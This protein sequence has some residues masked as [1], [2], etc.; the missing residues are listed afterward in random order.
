MAFE[1]RHIVRA[2]PD[3]ESVKR[4]VSNGRLLKSLCHGQ[5]ASD[6]IRR[7]YLADADGLLI[8]EIRTK[9]RSTVVGLL[10]YEVSDEYEPG[11]LMYIHVVCS[12]M[13]GVG[14]A[15]LAEA[16]RVAAG[17]SLRWAR[18]TALDNVINYYRRLGFRSTNHPQCKEQRAITRAASKIQHLRFNSS[19]EARA[20]PR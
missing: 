15:L 4:R 18:V 11:N 2:D 13:R 16:R 14:V 5:V 8:A 9:R 10:I 1:I 6:P 12:R 19:D 7:Y 17:L 20:D 3:W